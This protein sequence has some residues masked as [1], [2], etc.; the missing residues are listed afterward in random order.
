MS[1][2]FIVK[3]SR[4]D[5]ESKTPEII[6]HETD[7]LALKGKIVLSFIERWGMVAARDDMED[8]SGRAKSRLQQPQDS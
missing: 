1:I 3:P 5:F 8:S 2:S 6:A 4:Y 7:Y